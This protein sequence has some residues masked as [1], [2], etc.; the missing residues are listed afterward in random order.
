MIS[1]EFRIFG[2]LNLFR[3]SRFGFRNF[4]YSRCDSKSKATY[5]DS[6]CFGKE[7]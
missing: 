7:F 6:T 2:N 1:F 3:I 5:D 4:K